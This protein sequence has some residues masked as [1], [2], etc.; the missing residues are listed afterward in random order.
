MD[1]DRIGQQ[2]KSLG[3]SA[4]FGVT[5][6]GPSLKLIDSMLNRDI[7]YVPVKHE[8]SAAIMAGT[9]SMMRDEPSIS[10]CIKG[11]GVANL[12]PGLIYAHY[13][14]LPLL[15]I[16]EAY[17]DGNTRAH[18]RLD[19]DE[20]VRPVSK[21]Y[22]TIGERS[23]VLKD[24]W[25]VASE[26]RPGP[27]HMDLKPDPRPNST[28]APT[29]TDSPNKKLFDQLADSH[30]PVV[31]VGD[32]WN[33]VQGEYSFDSLQ[34]PIFTT[35]AGKGSIDETHPY[36][37]GVYTGVGKSCTPERTIINEADLIVGI[38]LQAKEL[39][40]NSGFD[41]PFMNVSTPLQKGQLPIPGA[42]KY[43]IGVLSDLIDG[44]EEFSWG[45]SIVSD[46]RERLQTAFRESEC[47][48]PE[49]IYL[50]QDCIQQDINWVV[51]EGLFSVLAEHQLTVESDDMFISPGISRFMG[52][53]VPM[54]LAAALARP[55][56]ATIA[57][58]GDGGIGPLFGELGLAVKKNLDL[59][60][61]IV[62]D[63]HFGTVHRNALSQ[64]L[65]PAP[66][67]ITDDHWVESLSQFGYNG[68]RTSN[69]VTAIDVV[70]EW[71][72]DPSPTVLQ[73]DVDPEQY[74]S[75]T[76]GIR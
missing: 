11:P 68:C 29:R 12:M 18:K 9:Y 34:V 43:P 72:R 7:D 75:I 17:P 23:S 22:K 16:S 57:I 19:H 76:K 46:T 63:G 49:L 65:N 45:R 60:I 2:A 14:D 67:R 44:L 48:I 8:Q 54:S 42:T 40:D 10:V 36:S 61:L 1:I 50:T 26:E 15:S 56:C 38:G 21:S 41:Q 62:S 74:S 32:L 70:E 27:V 64:G 59:L 28:K 52:V 3:V 47:V 53:G 73:I 24:A 39:L 6:S 30:F 55:D 33:R 31:I 13:E 5:G 71:R 20:L 4:A 69:V 58:I 51:D 66:T 37:A 35:V 25:E